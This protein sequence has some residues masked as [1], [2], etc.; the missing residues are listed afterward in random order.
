MH[1][2]KEGFTAMAYES[3]VY[4]VLI[5]S[6]SDV[7]TERDIAVSVIQEWNDLHSFTKKVTLLPLRWETHSAPLL[8]TRPQQII[9]KAIV[10]DS[11]GLPS[12]LWTRQSNGVTA[13]EEC[14]C[15]RKRVR[16]RS[17]K[18]TNS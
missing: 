18:P 13:M 4:R 14:P 9:N 2:T 1:C 6:P 8:G 15:I 17:L 3:R 5:A 11:D 16:G 10:D 7:D 12:F